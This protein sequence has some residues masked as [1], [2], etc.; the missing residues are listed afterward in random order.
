MSKVANVK[1]SLEPALPE[2]AF[3]Q[4]LERGRHP[5]GP[6]TDPAH[7]HTARGEQ[8]R[9][10]IGGGARAERRGCQRLLLESYKKILDKNPLCVYPSFRSEC[11]GGGIGRRTSFRD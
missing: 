5:T 7:V 9:R 2:W 3:P 1:D 4:A 8:H 11:R 10:S 6:Q